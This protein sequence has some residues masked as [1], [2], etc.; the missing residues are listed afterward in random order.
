MEWR[1]LAPA[2][3]DPEDYQELWERKCLI[4][5]LIIGRTEKRKSYD[6]IKWWRISVRVLAVDDFLAWRRFMAST[7]SQLAG[8]LIICEVSDGLEAVQ[9]AQ[10][11]QPDL[12]LLD[13]G[14]P[15]LNGIDA[16][17]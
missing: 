17:R 8:L 2:V 13:I 6:R 7:L 1:V 5:N 4:E 12:I 14:L 15:K 11:L 3:I 9:K 16:A 10:E